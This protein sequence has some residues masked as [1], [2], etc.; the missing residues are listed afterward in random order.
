MT[1]IWKDISQFEGLYQI[2]SLG[3][4]KSLARI[5]D[6]RYKKCEKILKPFLNKQGYLYVI[7]CK[8][9]KIT[10]KRINR[11]VAEAFI[12]NPSNKAYV[13]HKN[14]IKTD[15]SVENLE[16]VTP[17]E[18]SNYSVKQIKQYTK[19][20]EYIKTWN[21]LIIINEE[22]NIDKGNI[23]KCCKGKRKTAGGFIWKYSKSLGGKYNE[24]YNRKEK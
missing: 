17:K 16:W 19:N 14:E 23:V 5:V 3:N 18:N 21:N 15:N 10:D 12:P 7:L 1:E 2:S 11:L 9:G 20:N 6:N 8:N 13:N 24:N 4:V 22:L